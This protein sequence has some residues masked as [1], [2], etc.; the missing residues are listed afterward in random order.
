MKLLFSIIILLFSHFFSIQNCYSQNIYDYTHTEKFANYLFH[1]KDY[2]L[3]IQ[4]FERLIYMNPDNVDAKIK[5]IK[6]YRYLNRDSIALQRFNK[7]FTNNDVQGVHDVSQE[8]INLLINVKEYNK[9]MQYLTSQNAL[10]AEE[11]VCYQ[12]FIDLYSKSWDNANNSILNNSTIQNNHFNDLKNISAQALNIKYKKPW[13]SAGLSAIIP[14]TGKVYSG[15]WK[16]GLISLLFVGIT[17][18][19]AYRGFDKNGIN[20]IYGWIY[21]GVGF[22]F[23]VGNIYGSVKAANKYNYTQGHNIIHKVDKVFTDYTD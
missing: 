2:N 7:I 21:G 15:Y 13:V 11:K 1:S 12:V 20:S 4:E 19:Q 17:S 9:S 6:S 18:W 10:S 14:G 5:L 22:G 3:A 23:Y 8:Y 16:D